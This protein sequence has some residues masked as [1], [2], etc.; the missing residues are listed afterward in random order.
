MIPSQSHGRS[1]P[2]MCRRI[3][4]VPAL[5]ASERA[6]HDLTLHIP[7][8]LVPT[9]LQVAQAIARCKWC[10]HITCVESKTSVYPLFSAPLTA[11]CSKGS[12]Y[13]AIG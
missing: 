6:D 13:K 4:L 2:A 5:L 1:H 8:H 3:G 10:V 11:C 7:G 12:V 9:F